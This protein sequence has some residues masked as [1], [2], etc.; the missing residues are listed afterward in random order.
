[1][2][3]KGFQDSPSRGEAVKRKIPQS[4]TSTERMVDYDRNSAS[5]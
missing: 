1:M 3:T 2:S 5:G 4:V